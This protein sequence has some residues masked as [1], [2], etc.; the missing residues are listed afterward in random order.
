MDPDGS[1]P[2]PAGPDTQEDVR[3]GGVVVFQHVHLPPFWLNSP[4][5]WFLQVE[6]HIRLRQITSQQN[7]YLHLVSLPSDVA[8]Y[9]ADVIASPHSSHSFYTLKAAIIS[10]KSASEQIKLQ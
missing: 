10:H 3:P 1:S 7:K 9:L 8:E 5:T 4:S 6:A 2:L